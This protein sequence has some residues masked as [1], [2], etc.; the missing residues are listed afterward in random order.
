MPPIVTSYYVATRCDNPSLQQYFQ[1]TGSYSAGI[2]VRYQGFC[3]EIQAQ[4]GASGVN[5]ESSH[6]N[7]AACYATY[8]TTSTTT[9]TTAAPIITT[10]TT[11]AA[12]IIT[13]TTTT[14]SLCA[15]KQ[16]TIQDNNA[17]SYTD[18]A[19]VFQ[20]GSIEQGSEVCV[21]INQFY[22]ANIGNLID[23]IGCACS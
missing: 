1:T 5:P 11:T 4:A 16:G 15:C 3:W 21:D 22:S 7:C 2:S 19:G 13:T 14:A 20:S 8:P 6:I 23:F 9:T 17:F 10:T 18:C 12:P